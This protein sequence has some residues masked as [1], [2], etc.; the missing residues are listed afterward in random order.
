[1]LTFLS[2]NHTKGKPILIAAAA[3]KE[4]RLNDDWF[5]YYNQRRGW[6]GG[7]HRAGDGALGDQALEAIRQVSIVV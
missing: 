5:R 4:S 3:K 2:T 1:V 7:P 6:C